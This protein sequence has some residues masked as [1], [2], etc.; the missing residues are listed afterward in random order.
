M[1]LLLLNRKKG[2]LIEEI[3]GGRCEYIYT[4]TLNSRR[5]YLSGRMTI[6]G[7]GYNTLLT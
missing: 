1:R 2:G 4:E 5:R 7:I 3:I 6:N